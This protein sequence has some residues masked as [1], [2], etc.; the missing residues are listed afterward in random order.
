MKLFNR[1]PGSQTEPPGMERRI[2]RA[3]P[4]MLALGTLLPALY[5]LVLHLL[6]MGGTEELLRRVQMARYVAVGAILLNLM[7][8]MQAAM[9]CGIVALMK[10]HGYVA[11]AYALPDSPTPRA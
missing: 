1:L 8:V 9:L 10:G 2:L 3:L 4:A 6:A 5:V 11:D 7:V